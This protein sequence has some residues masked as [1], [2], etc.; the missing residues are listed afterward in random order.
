MK[1]AALAWEPRRKRR[2]M[3]VSEPGA[4]VTP[5]DGGAGR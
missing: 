3:T 4:G 2:M 1:M 5:G